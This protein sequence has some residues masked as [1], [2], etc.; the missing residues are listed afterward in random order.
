MRKRIYAGVL[1]ALLLAGCGAGGTETTPTTETP[2]QAEVL[3]TTVPT[4]VTPEV[5]ETTA[6]VET[7]APV[8]TTIPTEA[9]DPNAIVVSTQYGNLQ[10]QD[11]WREF[12]VTEESM[13]GENLTISFRAEINDIQYDLF[14]LTIGV[15]DDVPVGEITGPDGVKRNVYITLTE[16]MESDALTEGEQNRLY[17]MQEDINYVIENLK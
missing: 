8:E 10:Y 5:Q 3:E 4:E 17:A 2:T 6:V 14:A 15:V 16:I 1:C 7:T 9:V 11:Q 13:D 12:M